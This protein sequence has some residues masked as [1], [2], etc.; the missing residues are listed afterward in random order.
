[1]AIAG[2]L[3]IQLMAEMARLT[4][5]MRRAEKV[6]A[7]STDKM[8]RSVA[9]LESAFGKL[10]S[11]L[12]LG[13]AF[14]QVRRLTDD[15]TKLTA[16]LRIA[17]TSQAEYAAGLADVRRIS[18]AAQAD[19]LATTLLY[20]RLANALTQ[21]GATQKQVSNITES[22]SLGLKAY[23]ATST[24]AASAMLQL[25]QAFGAN[26][27]GGEEFRAVSEAMPNMMKILATSMGVPLSALKQLSAEGKITSEVMMKAWDNP[28][29]IDALRKQA[30]MTRTITGELTVFRNNLKMLVGEFMGASGSTS[31]ITSAIHLMSDAV[32][33]LAENLKVVLLAVTVL[34]LAYAGKFAVGMTGAISMT[35]AHS[36]ALAMNAAMNLAAA[37]ASNFG[38]KAALAQGAANALATGESAAAAAANVVYRKSVVELAAAQTAASASAVTGITAV[39]VAM[40][41]AIMANPILAAATAIGLI[42]VAIANWKDITDGSKAS[43]KWFRDD[44]LGG[45]EFLAAGVG[46]SLGELV[47]KFSLLANLTMPQLKSGEFKKQWDELGKLAEQSRIEAAARIAGVDMQ[48]AQSPANIVKK[49]EVEPNYNL[50]FLTKSMHALQKQRDEFNLSD[51][52]YAAGI[53]KIYEELNPKKDKAVEKELNAFEKMSLKNKQR[54]AELELELNG[55]SKLL[56]SEKDIADFRAAID[57]K[58]TKMSK[59]H[60]DEVLAGLEQVKLNEMLLRDDGLQLKA[61]EKINS[62]GLT[63]LDRMD[64][65]I[66]AQ[67]LH[68]DSIGKTAEQVANLKALEEARALAKMESDAK[69]LADSGKQDAVTLTELAN[70]NATIAKEKEFAAL[71]AAAPALEA[72]KAAEHEQKKLA[73]SLSKTFEDAFKKIFDGGVSMFKQLQKAFASTV[74]DSMLTTIYDASLKK[75]IQEMS[76]GI[77]GGIRGVMN[78]PMIAAAMPYVTAAMLAMPVISGMFNHQASAADL[79]AI[80]P[81]FIQQWQGTGTVLGDISA[82]STSVAGS[83]DVLNKTTFAHTDYLAQMNTSM[84]NVD[85][86][87]NNFITVAGKALNLNMASQTPLGTKTTQNLSGGANF[88]LSAGMGALITPIVTEAIGFAAASGMLGTTAAAAVEAIGAAGGLAMGAAT[89]GIGLVLSPLIGSFL[90]GLF[91]SSSTTITGTGINFGGTTKQLQAGQGGQQYTSGVT[92]SDSFFGLSSSSSTWTQYAALDAKVTKAMGAIFKNIGDTIAV[93]AA[94]LGGNV[95]AITKQLDA[96]VISTGNISMAGMTVQQQQDAL[97]N[98]VSQQSDLMVAA[99][100]PTMKAFQISGEGLLQTLVRVVSEVATLTTFHQVLGDTT[101]VTAASADKLITALGGVDAANQAMSKFVSNFAPETTKSALALNALEVALSNAGLRGVAPLIKTTQDYFALMQVASADQRVILLQQQD[102]ALA[103]IKSIGSAMNL[104]LDQASKQANITKNELGF[105]ITN[106]SS[107][108]SSLKGAANSLYQSFMQQMTPDYQRQQYKASL[109]LLQD[110]YTNYK[111]TGVAPNAAGLQQAISNVS[112]GG[113]QM[114]TSAV[115]WKRSTIQTIDLLS[116]MGN[117]AD[118]QVTVLTQISGTMDKLL[119]ANQ[120]MLAATN[121]GN[122]AA[123]ADAANRAAA[124][125]VNLQ[126]LQGVNTLVTNSAAQNTLVIDLV[127]QTVAATSGGNSALIDTLKKYISSGGTTMIGSGATTGISGAT[128]SAGGALAA[129]TA[130]GALNQVA[131]MSALGSFASSGVLNTSVAPNAMNNMIPGIQSANVT[132]AALAQ[133]QIAAQAQQQTVADAAASAARVKAKA[134]ALAASDAARLAVQRFNAMYNATSLKTSPQLIPQLAALN[135][136]AVAAKAKY[137]SLPSFAVGVNTVPFDMTANIHKGEEIKPAA[138]VD[139]E[140]NARDETNALLIRL[141]ASN[142]ASRGELIN[143]RAELAEIK[144]TNQNMEWTTDKWDNDGI[145][146]TRLA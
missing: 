87:L 32:L 127:A 15:Y 72:T 22:V 7:D 120:E 39:G 85:K 125:S 12:S 62:A 132:A 137:D 31:G 93:A 96:F 90:G 16:Q 56:Q 110:A 11:T 70:L 97:S 37:E 38:A 4:T 76:M 71:K 69:R 115:D 5:D 35:L 129:G 102:T 13:I 83:L 114:F 77:S 119:A 52:Q 104:M 34:S 123:A 45:M 141:V 3:E 143:M 63:N 142:D 108:A 51:A 136:A 50:E 65:E 81:K 20:T 109:A 101:A 91:G 55:N 9:T 17:T 42:V 105:V 128:S 49:I 130:A 82:K 99:V 122:V 80:D 116:G 139:R 25:S 103:Y 112:S 30:D 40:R 33:V 60:Q 73:E 98:I 26:R 86:G 124:L 100:V 44:F 126:W 68:N 67:R 46:I 146:A 24:E 111:A 144:R 59:P 29:V 75:P 84:K 145:P 88:L 79:R 23:G 66:A 133:Q 74:K 41:T 47:Q 134:D 28:A 107:L 140:R 19:I 14:D 54:L 113:T 121:A 21:H 131:G 27:L 92:T 57:S 61:M 53:K 94:A 58:Q 2:I 18:T 64:K 36:E 117:L 1:M 43:L 6:V 10:G 135:A 138:Y 8:G 48:K 118:A 89:M 106:L 95:A 78:S